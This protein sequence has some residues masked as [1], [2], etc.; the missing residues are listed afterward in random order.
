MNRNSLQDNIGHD[1]C[2]AEFVKDVWDISPSNI[3]DIN[4]EL[5]QWRTNSSSDEEEVVMK[6]VIEQLP[7]VWSEHQLN[8]NSLERV[9]TQL[10]DRS[11]RKTRW[12]LKRSGCPTSQ[13]NAVHPE[14]PLVPWKDSEEEWPLRVISAIDFD[15]SSSDLEFFI[16]K[17]TQQNE[18]F[19]KADTELNQHWL[20]HKEVMMSS[21]K[22]KDLSSHPRYKLRSY[23]CVK[24]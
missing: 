8:E 3:N 7:K 21:T 6:E 2:K 20:G 17:T 9:A 5:Q 22:A 10:M 23:T 15:A 11:N 4:Q 16:S 13:K 24:M 18:N 14:R 12:F 19:V 1:I